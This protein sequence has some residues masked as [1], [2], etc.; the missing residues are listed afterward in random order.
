M[1]KLLQILMLVLSLLWSCKSFG[2]DDSDSMHNNRSSVFIE[3]GG[4]AA[5]L[6]VNYEYLTQTRR[7]NVKSAFAIG[8]THHFTDPLDF[9]VAPQYSLLIGNKLMAETGAGL[10]IPVSYTHQW[11]LIARFGARYQKMNQGFYYRLAFTPVISLRNDMAF[12][13]MAGISIGYRFQSKRNM[14]RESTFKV[15]FDRSCEND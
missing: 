3:L 9:I 4:N 7:E 14:Q 10:T 1:K 12:L 2:Q 11:V 6:S 13:P 8:L 15:R 5:I